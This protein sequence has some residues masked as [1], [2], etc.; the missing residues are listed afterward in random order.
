MRAVVQQTVGGNLTVGLIERPEPRGREILVRIEHSALNRMD[1]LQAKGTNAQSLPE[2]ASS[3]LGVEVSGII[4]QLGPDCEL[5]FNVNDI[6]MALLLG[7]GYA[8]YCVVDERTVIPSISGVD[9]KTLAAIPEAFMTA[10]QLVFFVAQVKPHESILIHACASSVGQAAIQMA[11]RKGIKVFAT[12]RTD[13]KVQ[14]CHSLGA[15]VALRVDDTNRFADAIM[16]A[17]DGKGV[18]TI[19]DPVGASYME[20]NVRLAA[21]DGKIILYGL[22]GGAQVND[23]SFLGKLIAKR[24]SLLPTTLRTRSVEYKAALIQALRTDP[25]GLPAIATGDIRVDVSASFPLEEA[26]RAHAHMAANKNI[27][28]IVLDVAP[29]SAGVCEASS[30]P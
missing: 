9:L 13:E 1:L 12:A 30:C 18:N 6:V 22:M 2:G 16:D 8:E 14:H 5:G 23:P 26:Q 10:Y 3:I 29:P 15:T 25:D 20:E 24:I 7:G 21:V 4:E 11:K 17:N 28:K 27:G 19:F